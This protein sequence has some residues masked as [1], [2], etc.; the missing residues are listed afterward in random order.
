M[1]TNNRPLKAYVR[2]DG[3]GRAVSSSLIWRKNKPK[4][5]KWKEVQGYECCDGGGGTTRLAT[6]PLI[7]V[8]FSTT[9]FQIGCNSTSYFFSLD[10]IYSG[11]T[12]EEWL[13]YF[14]TF[15]GSMGTFSLNSDN[16]G[17]VFFDI[18]TE[19]LNLLCDG[20]SAT[21]VIVPA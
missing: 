18:K 12:A 1:A 6:D 2:F 20:T 16:P 19:T 14:N 4:V 13:T 9:N 8:D 17:Q 10:G 21:F 5:G 11:S 3:S 7:S 15:Y